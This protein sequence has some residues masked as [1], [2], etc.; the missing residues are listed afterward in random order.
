MNPE[1][2]SKSQDGSVRQGRVVHRRPDYLTLNLLV[3]QSLTVL[4][5]RMLPN[6]PERGCYL[7]HFTEGEA[8]SETCQSYGW[9]V[10]SLQPILAPWGKALWSQCVSEMVFF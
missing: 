8:D 2:Y 9:W 1:Y 6:N 3:T 5:S 7:S 10:P 4:T